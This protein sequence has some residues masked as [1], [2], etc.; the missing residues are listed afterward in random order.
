MKTYINEVFSSFQGEGK[1]IGRRQIFIRFCGCNLDCNYCDTPQSRDLVS[2]EKLSTMDLLKIVNN[3]ITPDFHSI[4]LTG[5]EPLLHTEFIKKFIKKTNFS[6]L[7][8]TNGSLPL[9][10]R[11][12]AKLINYASVDIKLP[13]HNSSPNWD[14]LIRDEL[15]SINIL[16]EE[17]VNT[18]CKVVILPFTKVDIVKSIASKI[19]KDVNDVSEL[20]MVIQPVGPYKNWFN[21]AGNLFKISEN[22]GE[23]LEV[24]VIPP[25]HKLLKL[26]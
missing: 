23:Y 3:F 16:I 15:E 26:R 12:L 9:N 8:E 19:Y 24:L 17:G 1:L 7:L 22:V 10:V 13:E 6:Y 20:P 2:G 25:V 18:Y 14:D 4:S 5:G 11:K 21:N